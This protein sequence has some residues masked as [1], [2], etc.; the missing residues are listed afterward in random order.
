MLGSDRLVLMIAIGSSFIVLRV[1][2]VLLGIPDTML[3]T[4]MTGATSG[5]IGSMVLALIRHRRVP[6]STRPSSGAS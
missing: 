1:L 6:D 5:L 2:G 3:V 4:G